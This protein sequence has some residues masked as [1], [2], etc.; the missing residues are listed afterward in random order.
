[1]DVIAV[2]WDL[3]EQALF[4]QEVDKAIL[5]FQ[6]RLSTPQKAKL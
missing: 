6:T 5:Q 4:I 3:S 1:M 2:M